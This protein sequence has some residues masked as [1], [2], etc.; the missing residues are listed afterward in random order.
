MHKGRTSAGRSAGRLNP[1]LVRRR[2]VS[3]AGEA[4]AR[5]PKL[6]RWRLRPVPPPPL[7][8]LL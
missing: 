6:E 1:S 5:P 4:P 3:G 7:L 2:L 8:M